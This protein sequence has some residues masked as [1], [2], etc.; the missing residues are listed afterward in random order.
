MRPTDRLVV[1]NER[2]KS[3]DNLW[4]SS[5]DDSEIRTE[6]PIDSSFQIFVHSNTW[7]IEFPQY[8][9]NSQTV[10]WETGKTETFSGAEKT[11]NPKK[12]TTKHNRLL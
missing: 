6:F 10:R 1:R 11:C 8:G 12:K 2:E 3:K 5:L 4:D 7:G 9:S